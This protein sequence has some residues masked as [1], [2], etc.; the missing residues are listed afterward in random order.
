MAS[1]QLSS[2]AGVALSLAFAY[3]PGVKEWYAGLE[4]T[5]KSTVMAL[6]IIAIAIVAFG[7]SCYDFVQIG[8]VCDKV[9][10]V[11]LVS[12][13]IAALVANQSAYVLLVRPFVS[14]EAV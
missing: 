2:I 12:N 8:I 5:M 7:L 4:K 11:A 3:I 13:V 14:Q 9:G 10:A 1:E 6:L